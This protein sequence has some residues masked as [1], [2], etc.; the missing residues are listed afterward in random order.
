M[1]IIGNFI[2]Y[3]QCKLNIPFQAK[4]YKCLHNIVLYQVYKFHFIQVRGKFQWPVFMKVEEKDKN[5]DCQL[6]NPESV[7]VYAMH[8]HY[9]C[10]SNAV[11][12]IHA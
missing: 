9:A 4:V 1:Q 3:G 2:E 8:I 5:R 6:K 7:N 10:S 12:E 11:I